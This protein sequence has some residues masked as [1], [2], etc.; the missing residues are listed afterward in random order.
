MEILQ[1]HAREVPLAA[2]AQLER[3]AQRTPG[4]SGA[5]LANVINEAALLAARR[6]K[7]E[8]TGSELYEAVENLYVLDVTQRRL[9]TLANLLPRALAGREAEPQ[10]PEE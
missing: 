9:F 5:D 3:I 2:D 10:E 8:I 4:F 6:N 1:V 7:S